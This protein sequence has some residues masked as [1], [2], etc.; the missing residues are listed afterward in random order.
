M[1]DNNRDGRSTPFTIYTDF[2][3]KSTRLQALIGT[4]IPPNLFTIG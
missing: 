2:M 1:D 4:V 3:A